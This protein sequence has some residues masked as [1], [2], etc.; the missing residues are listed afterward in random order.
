[1]RRV[2]I[3]AYSAF[4][5]IMLINFFYYNNL[6]KTQVRYII[7]LLDR[8]VLIVGLEVDSTNN[9]F[10]SDLTQINFSQD[11]SRFFDK[12]SP[13]IQ[14]RVKEQLKLFFS[15]YR[16]FI[17]K[18]RVYDNN[19]NEYT[20]SKD[21]EW[22]E[23]EFTSLD[24][25][26]I[27]EMEKLVQTGNEFNYYMPI[28]KNGIP[29]GNIVVTVD[30][31][32]FFLKLYS[33]F[34]LKDYQWQWVVSDNG[35]IIYDNNGS[36]ISY[37]QLDHILSGLED[38][39]IS[40]ITH[41]AIIGK[42]RVEIL[43][44]YYSTQLLQRDLG[45]VFTAPT[46][47]FQKYIIRNSLFIVIGTLLIIQLIIF[48]F[49]RYMRKQST[50]IQRLSDSEKM[51]MRLIE[52]MPAGVIIFNH[53]REILKA[54]K[55][56]AGFY[57]YQNES[58]MLGKIYP[59]S[60]LSEDSNYF[61]KYLVG[62]FNPEQ[63]VIIKKEIGEVVLYR[64]SIPVRFLG[65]EATLEVLIDITM[66]ES[67]RK[68]E[69]K[70][71]VAKSEFLA[72]MS[73]EIRTPLNGIIGM[74]D[75]LNRFELSPGLKD[76][77]SLLRRSTEVLLNIINDILDFSKIESGKMILDEIPFD[78][79]EEI[80]YA[81]DLAK[82]HIGEKEINI[83]CNVES[84][85]P[86]MIIGDSF[87]LR[88]ILAN[89]INHSIQNTEKGEIKVLCKLKESLRGIITLQ[90]E[91]LD[92]G[93]SFEKA[94]FKKIF[95]EFVDTD[96]FSV[97]SNDESAFSTIIARQLI[98]LMGGQL[99]ATSPSGLSGTMG[100][101]VMFT[102]KTF[103]NERQEKRLDVSGIKQLSQI[104][105][106]VMMGN[107][108]RDDDFLGNLHKI[109][110]Q[111]S[112]TTFQKMTINQIRT[113]STLSADKYNLLIIIDDEDFNGFVPAKAIW[114]EKLSA[115]FT[116]IMVSSNDKKGNYV[117]C[118]TM[119]VDHY[120]VKPF[121]INDLIDALHTSFP[122]LVS[123]AAA[124]EITNLKKDLQILIVEDNKMNQNIL[125][126]M[127]KS[128]GYE[129]DLAEDGYDGYLMAKEKK[130][131]IIFMD[132]IMPEMDGFESAR[133]IIDFDKN[134]LLVAFT[135]DNMPETRKK[136]ELSGIRDFVSKPV[137]LEELKKL[138]AKYFQ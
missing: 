120:L 118:I 20:L 51:F 94:A 122:G 131:D 129:S 43:S 62:T 112:V 84:R 111:V 67:A 125:I 69:A 91:V 13:E 32:R 24:Q 68:Q 46:A 60:R 42:E 18:I 98:E 109:G 115:L 89:I 101:K 99:T 87:R 65:T 10:V 135:A 102:I 58:D 47:F 59:E 76:I 70:A 21:N 27:E 104:R 37:S 66:L 132:L 123:T 33:R 72:R 61:S 53:N 36:Q 1:M 8:Q 90:F 34:N 39:E 15:K 41:Q 92:T 9:N 105:A 75:V 22:I 40:N 97:K 52:E 44:S 38:G 138:F 5:L 6:Y 108:S 7:E 128:L 35:E 124:S 121:D 49:W 126:H 136:A 93:R 50:S 31:R 73:Y 107:Q 127:L 3:I 14:F 17:T 82:A 100:T 74:A 80:Y 78:L 25:R 113:N 11:A 88:Q 55:I 134:S 114:D 96:S 133:R 12:T 19:L 130:Y 86:E 23:G 116:I 117:N 110:I 137:R 95:G 71:N 26:K 81:I 4:V 54:N 45:L 56:A 103:L 77:V 106:L 28:L 57:A 85:V 29:N 16:D 30:F 64:A 79:R 119:G 83:T 63:F 2:I 48:V